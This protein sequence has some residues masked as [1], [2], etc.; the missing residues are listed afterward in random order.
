MAGHLGQLSH[1]TDKDHVNNRVTLHTY[2]PPGTMAICLT[3]H[4]NLKLS[5]NLAC[6]FQFQT[7]KEFM[8]VVQPMPMLSI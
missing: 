6:A 1:Y 4:G 7:H 2:S 5:F 3:A 8:S